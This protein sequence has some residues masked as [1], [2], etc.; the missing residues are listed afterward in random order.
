MSLELALLIVI[1]GFFLLGLYIRTFVKSTVERSIEHQFALKL[2][3]FKQDFEADWKTRERMDRFRL[4]AIDERLK[5]TQSAFR[6]WRKMS[7][8]LHN[9]AIRPT[10]IQELLEFWD[11]NSLYMTSEA[12]KAFRDA[13]NGYM[14][15][16]YLRSMVREQ[17]EDK[18]A[19]HMA[20]D[21]IMKAFEKITT[22]SIILEKSVDLESMGEDAVTING[23]KITPFEEEDDVE[24]K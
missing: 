12:R 11:N 5:T 2:E 14:N 10:I 22:L 21:E 3:Q 17:R 23:K 4:A 13:M 1:C 20:T 18:E 19:K 7:V 24:S 8:T 16:E 15:Y 6:L 9:K